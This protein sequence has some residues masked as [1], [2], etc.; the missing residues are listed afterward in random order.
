MEVVNMALQFRGANAP[1]F[2]DMNLQIKE[3]EKVLIVGPSGSGKSTLLNILSGL[4]PRVIDALLEADHMDLLGEGAVVFQDPDSQFT[5]PTIGEELAFIME[6]NQVP[7]CDMTSNALSVLEAVGL[8]KPLDAQISSLSG[9]MK[10]KLSIASALLQKADTFFFDEPTSMLDENTACSLWETIQEVWEE[11]TVVIV[12][13]RVEHVWFR[14]DRIILLNDEGCIAASATPDD[15]LNDNREA[16]DALGVWHPH[17]WQNAPRFAKSTGNGMPLLQIK[18][19]SINRAGDELLNVDD[20]HI[21]KGQWITL[22][23]KNGSGKS[24][25]MM[26]VMKLMQTRG[27]IIFEGRRIRK[28][29]Q[30]QGALYPVFQNPELQFIT[31]SVFG[32]VLINLE[33][34]Y[35]EA[36]AERKTGEVLSRMGL[37]HIKR[38]H[39]LE[40]STG[41]K[42]RLSVAT[43]LGGIPQ[44]IFLDEPTFG[45]DARHTFKLLE[46]MHELVEGGTTII[47]ITHDKEIKERYPS[48]RL[49]IH[50]GIMKEVGSGV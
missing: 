1:L 22:E 37:S 15:M 11:R 19:L 16:L 21:S 32:E 20:L 31:N 2:T 27:E 46:L 24:S 28:T 43:A 5:M 8:E 48:R 33:M 40:I 42:R 29:K 25:F 14:V 45:L 9:G 41:Q 30:F 10:Q 49:Q 26:A 34:H 3:G 36:E 6:N 38:L 4:M 12:E 39:P 47:M 7:V 35:D 18:G 44:I 17:S 23:G 50:D 13:H